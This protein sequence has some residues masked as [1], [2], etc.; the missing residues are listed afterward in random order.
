MKKIFISRLF[1]V[2][3]FCALAS[4]P[5]CNGEEENFGWRPGPELLIRY[6]DDG[7]WVDLTTGTLTVNANETFTFGVAGFS[8]EEDYIW[9]VTGSGAVVTPG[10]SK[11]FI[12]VE[13]TQAGSVT[14]A[15]ENRKYSGDVVVTVN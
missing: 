12:E 11:E 14:I 4:L 5:S 7:S 6:E 3:I 8:V 1:A 15:I 10:V 13:F 9:T 2:A